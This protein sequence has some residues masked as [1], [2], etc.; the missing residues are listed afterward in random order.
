MV[1]VAKKCLKNAGRK[2]TMIDELKAKFLDKAGKWLKAKNI[3]DILLLVIILTSAGVFSTSNV[4]E[5]RA[6]S[7]ETIVAD[8]SIQKAYF[9]YYNGYNIGLI[10]DKNDVKSILEEI[11]K[12]FE[13]KYNMET[14]TSHINN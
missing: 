2:L 1:T 12:E 11:R 7:N 3:S 8:E 9:T 5:A 13:K 6:T 4:S 14:K 10:K